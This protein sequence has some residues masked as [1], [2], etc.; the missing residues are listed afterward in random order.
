[1]VSLPVISELHSGDFTES[2]LRR[3]RLR[4][5]GKVMGETTTA[6]YRG[7]VFHEAVRILHVGRKWDRQ[8]IGIAVT[9]AAAQVEAE[10]KANR[11]PL[12][13]AVEEKKFTTQTE[14]EK[15]VQ[16]YAG[17]LAPVVEAGSLIGCEMPIRLTLDVDGEPQ[18]FAS[19]LDLLY[20]QTADEDKPLCLWDFKTGEDAPT[21]AFLSRNLQLG[22]YYLAL[23]YG[24]V[25]VDGEWLEFDEWPSVW[26]IHANN[27]A[28]YKRAGKYTDLDGSEVE[29]KAGDMRP[30]QTVLHPCGFS[31][32]KEEAIRAALVE[33]VRMMRAGFWPASPDPVGCHICPSN[34]HCESF[35]EGGE[36]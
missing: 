25:L 4:H 20:R 33:R 5:E 22:F 35:C 9:K 8:S 28:P 2:C 29:Y 18:E 7:S 32:D 31:P 16:R 36:A 13:P 11:K 21:R 15:L 30:L 14:V 27:L 6:L 12:S 10:A 26:W 1:M 17:L 34:R 19:H 24:S 23:R 3:V